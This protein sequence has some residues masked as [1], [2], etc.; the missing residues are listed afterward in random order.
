MMTVY[1]QRKKCVKKWNEKVPRML[2]NT[3][4]ICS[5]RTVQI[6][7]IVVTSC[8]TCL[9]QPDVPLPPLWLC[10]SAQLQHRRWVRPYGQAS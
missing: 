5:L 7:C 8:H 10:L 9:S 2:P 3:Y 6:A 1:I 4:F